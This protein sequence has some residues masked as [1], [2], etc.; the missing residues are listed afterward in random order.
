MHNAWNN[1]KFENWYGAR[2][3]KGKKVRLFFSYLAGRAM[4]TNTSVFVLFKGHA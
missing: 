2:K 3:G 4:T 1:N